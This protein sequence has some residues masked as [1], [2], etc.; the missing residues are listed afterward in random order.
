M[1]LQNNHSICHINNTLRIAI[2]SS[3]VSVV[4]T[5]NSQLFLMKFEIEDFCFP[6]LSSS[7]SYDRVQQDR[8][9][10][11]AVWG[12]NT[13]WVGG[14]NQTTEEAQSERIYSFSCLVFLN[15]NDFSFYELTSTLLI[16]RR[17]PEME[18]NLQPPAWKPI[19]MN[20]L[21]F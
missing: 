6:S 16:R 9:Y 11:P 13:S 3:L 8:V 4:R 7:S 18:S 19:T 21:L 17:L 20:Y 2:F 15:I 10:I 14:T 1:P 5:E 12:Y